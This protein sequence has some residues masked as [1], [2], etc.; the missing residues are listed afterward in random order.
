MIKH[1]LI[2]LKDAETIENTLLRIVEKFSDRVILTTEV[3]I[4]NGDTSRGINE[5]FTA[6]GKVNIHT[7]IDSQKDFET[8]SPFDECIFIKGNSNEV[9]NQL[10]D[11][12]QHFIF[13]DANHSFPYVVS[14]FFCFETKVKPLGYIAF[15]DTGK[16]IKFMTGYQF[17]GNENDQDMHISV[18]KALYRI[19][20]LSDRFPG[21][22]LIYD[23]ADTNDEMG[24]VC[25]FQKTVPTYK[26]WN[27]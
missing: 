21:W 1:G 5:F 6:H 26:L 12:S 13:I 11:E 22:K 14:D 10:A 3:G 8:K 24:G 23:E 15:H 27:L 16:H 2:S 20:L 19:G 18:R 7:A 4:F 9:Y 25:V 17:C